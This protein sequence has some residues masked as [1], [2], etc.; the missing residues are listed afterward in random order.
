MGKKIKKVVGIFMA[1]A[2]LLS[3]MPVCESHA[4]TDERCDIVYIVPKKGTFETQSLAEA[5]LAASRNSGVEIIVMAD[6]ETDFPDYI[7]YGYLNEDTILLVEGGATLTI[8]KCNFRMD[9]LLM[10]RGKVDIEHS[11]GYMYGSGT[12]RLLDNGKILKRPYTIDKKGENS[13]EA[14]DITY[15]Q[16]LAD[17][18]ITTDKVNWLPSIEGTWHF[19]DEEY[20]PQAGTRNHDVYFLPKYPLSYETKVFEKSGKV[21]TKQAVP[22]LEHYEKPQIHIG[23]NLLDVHPELTFV[24]PVTGET[25]EGEFTFEKSNELLSSIGEQEVLGTFNPKDA[26]YSAVTQYFKVDVLATEP[27][28]MEKPI[29]RNQ[30][31]YGQTLQDIQYLQGRCTNPYTGKVVKGTWEWS[32]PNERLCLGEQSYS[33]LFVPEEDGYRR[34][35]I[36]M[37]VNTYPKVMEN[38]TWPACSDITYGQSLSESKLS[39]TKNEYGTFAW[40]NENIRPTVKN[41]GVEVVFTPAATDTYDWSRIAGYDEE[42]KTITFTIPIQVHS[43]KAELPTFQATPIEEGTCV[44]GSALSLQGMPGSLE[45]KNPQQSA[46]VSD[47]YEVYYTPEDANNYDWSDYSPQEDGKITVSVYLQVIPK[48][49]VPTA[50]PTQNITPAPTPT[51]DITPTPFP[52][53]TAT[54]TPKDD[55]LLSQGAQNKGSTSVGDSDIQSKDTQQMLSDSATPNTDSSY[56]I[57]Q[58]V[59]RI[60][61]ITGPNRIKTTEIKKVKRMGKKVKISWKKVS[62]AKYVLQYSTNKKMKKAKKVSAGKASVMLTGLRKGKAYYVRIRAWKKKNGK[63]VYGKWSKIKRVSV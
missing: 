41:Q 48:P 30:G 43:I 42:S 37:P 20:V 50:T 9:G 49:I 54:P 47:W 34:L 6:R 45:W 15:G 18:T 63:K 40:K 27:A 29:I 39:F 10:V 3:A 55:L 22:Q 44:S 61:T 13:L 62:G 33:M 12:V 58:L 32:N 60:S 46:D 17:A 51:P 7:E 35:E 36:E 1:L 57:T 24:S 52:T 23:E 56:V 53:E 38:L 4:A 26:N 2:M 8:N 16:K 5:F 25:I 59:S 14:K 19:C 28:I 31:I 21:T 11:E